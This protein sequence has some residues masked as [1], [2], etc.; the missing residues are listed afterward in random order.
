MAVM[1]R[2]ISIN[3][4]KKSGLLVFG[5]AIVAFS[6]VAAGCEDDPVEV[7]H[8]PSAPRGVFSITGDRQVEICWLANPERDL[9]GYDI[10]YH[11]SRIHRTDPEMVFERIATVGPNTTCYIDTDLDNGFT[12]DFAVAAFDVGGLES[13]LS[14]E[15]VFDTPRPEGVGL[16]LH[17]YL[18]QNSSTSGYD[19]S[20]L[21]NT[22]QLWSD[23]STD[24]YFGAPNGMPTLFGKGAMVGDGVDVQ[25]YGYIDLEFVDWAPEID[26]GW[27]PFKKTDLIQ[28]HSYVI[29]IE[30]EASG[31]YHYAK[32]YVVSVTDQV[33]V[34]DW[35]YQISPGN[36]EL[37][38]GIGG[39]QK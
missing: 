35:A 23:S 6:F 15:D 17:D 7:N 31:F 25:D 27:S 38:P 21:N 9:A 30:D 18:G 36:P 12:Y 24:V 2:K 5:L 33:V 4:R 26:K 16:V 8:P 13:E 29:Q 14:R 20:R 11:D 10:Y 32:V 34:L 37:S 1:R 3:I 22:A 28:G 19:F 39:A